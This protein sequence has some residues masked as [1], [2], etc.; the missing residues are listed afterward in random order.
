LPDQPVPDKA[1]F[2]YV[3]KDVVVLRLHDQ[4]QRHE[5][6]LEDIAEGAA[7]EKDSVAHKTQNRQLEDVKRMLAAR[8]EK[9]RPVA[10]KD[11]RERTQFDLQAEISGLQERIK[12]AQQNEKLLENLVDTLAKDAQPINENA[13]DQGNL[14]AEVKQ[15]E[16][17]LERIGDEQNALAIELLA[18]PRVSKM[19]EAVIQT[20]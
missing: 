19:E 1:V 18:P 3:E 6:Q 15:A 11:Y 9:L 5:A 14:E 4:I 7:G 20:D 12:L 2:D 13:L 17:W 8:R 10:E 16:R